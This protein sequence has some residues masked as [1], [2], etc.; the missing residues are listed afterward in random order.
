MS[1]L[2]VSVKCDPKKGKFVFFFSKTLQC[3]LPFDFF[4]LMFIEFYGDSVDFKNSIG[5]VCPQLLIGGNI[6]NFLEL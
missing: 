4:L 1:V 3:I 2:F 5:D 6:G